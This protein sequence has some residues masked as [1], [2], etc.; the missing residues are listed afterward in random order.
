MS[1]NTD[2]SEVATEDGL[3]SYFIGVQFE[4]VGPGTLGAALGPKVATAEDVSEQLMYE[5]F[6]SYPVNDGMT[7]TPL[8]YHKEFSA[9]GVPDQTGLMV[10][11]SFAF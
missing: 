8:V 4:E 10:K 3:T 2:G 6:Y 1:I 9:N 7:I 5:I 11:T